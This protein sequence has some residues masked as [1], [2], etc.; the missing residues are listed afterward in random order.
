MKEKNKFERIVDLRPAFDRRDPDPRKNHGV[1]GVELIMVL[2]GPEGAI[3]FTIFTNWQLPDVQD[4]QD[5]RV[6]KRSAEGIFEKADLTAFYHPWAADLGY[7]SP[8]PRYE[9]QKAIGAERMRV[10]TGGR[11]L[12]TMTMEELSEAF[13]VSE[14]GTFTPCPYLDGQA[15]YYDG[16]GL[17]AEP[18]F[19]RLLR[20]GSEGVWLALEE[21]YQKIFGGA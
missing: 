7:H 12:Q 1:H 17:Q 9:G 10:A 14:T 20:E 16:S 19:E 11:D 8:K 21:H 4:M 18:V 2:K 13:Q 15:C 5:E 6:L 3:S